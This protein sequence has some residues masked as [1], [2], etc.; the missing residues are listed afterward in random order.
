MVADNVDFPREGAVPF[1]EASLMQGNRILFLIK[2][3][4][5]LLKESRVPASL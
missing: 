2:A 5:D 1:W 3:I 4:E